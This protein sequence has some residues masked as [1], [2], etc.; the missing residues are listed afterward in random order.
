M[1]WRRE[2]SE[3]TVTYAVLLHA[4]NVLITDENG[5]ACFG[6]A[7]TW[8]YVKASD[9]SSARDAAIRSLRE[10]PAFVSEVQN[11]EQALSHV[12][13]ED[14][15]EVEHEDPSRGTGVVFYIDSDQLM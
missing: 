8:R 10:T 4:R 14:I 5:R 9:R 12:E 11:L 15:L 3:P 6:G 2:S 1:P 7:Y 13:A